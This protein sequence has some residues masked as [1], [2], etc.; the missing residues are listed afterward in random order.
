MTLA[1]KLLQ[2]LVL[3]VCSSP[4]VFPRTNSYTPTQYKSFSSALQSE[5]NPYLFLLKKG[6]LPLKLQVDW[7]RV[8][9]LGSG[10][11]LAILYNWVEVNI[12]MNGMIARSITEDGDGLIK[13]TLL[14]GL[15]SLN[16]HFLKFD[17]N[18][19]KILVRI[20][21]RYLSKYNA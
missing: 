18:P 8:L 5:I 11:Q 20:A 17:L 19:V 2:N 16:W 21:N 15:L 13:Q 7:H 6:V 1:L 12:K 10:G 4:F 9:L 3:R 14:Q